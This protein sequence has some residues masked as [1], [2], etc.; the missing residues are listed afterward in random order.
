M[1]KRNKSKPSSAKALEG[2]FI[3]F[4]GIDG[5]GSTTQ[6]DL[7]FKYLK[8]KGKK[9]VYT[10]EPTDGPIGKLIRQA[11]KHQL[12]FSWETLQL[13]YSADRADHL[14]KLILPSLK[15][16]VSV[17]SDRYFFS[18][19]AYGEL[20]LDGKWLR[21]LSQNFPLPDITF[22]VDVP[23]GVAM[24]RIKTS[25]ENKELYEKQKLLEKVRK[26]YLDLA[27]E[28]KFVVLDGAKSKQEIAREVIKNLDE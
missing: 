15:V 12:K 14:D 2:K 1:S 10:C 5:A 4:E 11:L 18:T 22:L 21:Q 17:I 3:V 13:M 19:F 25:R 27:K 9:V 7:L 23:V 20:N 26:N 16:G 6:S 28:F 24:K 8:S